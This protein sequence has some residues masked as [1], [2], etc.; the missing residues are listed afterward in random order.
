MEKKT[1]KYII[2]MNERQAR[3]LSWVCDQFP[4]LIE[5][6]GSAYQDLFEAAWE[7]RCEKAT[8]EIMDK[9]YE[10]GWYKMRDDAETFCKEIKRRFW[11]LAPNAN[12]G[13]NYDDVSDII[14]DMHQAIRYELWKNNPDPN[15]STM[16]VDAF[17]AYQ[18]GVEP[19]IKVTSKDE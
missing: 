19:L 6:Q 13:V 7:K 12:W 2:E 10:G 17:P 5:G 18:F 9:E 3:L 8:G 11:D 15:K 4:R 16:T 14:W 1:K